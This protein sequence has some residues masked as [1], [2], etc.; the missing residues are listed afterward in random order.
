MVKITDIPTG[1]IFTYTGIRFNLLDPTPDMIDIRDIAHALSQI[2]R[3]GGHTNTFCSVATHSL[4]CAL[5]APAEIKLEALLH[6]AA[7]A[8]IGD[9]TSPLKKMLPEFQW[10]ENRVMQVVAKKF[11]LDHSK[12]ALTKEQDEA[13]LI[14]EWEIFMQDRSKPGKEN[15]TSHWATEKEFLKMYEKLKRV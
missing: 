6:D 14:R 12:L 13:A 9:M 5:T 1:H 4:Y 11:N 7:E 2:C 15:I 3:F 8:Y 10:H